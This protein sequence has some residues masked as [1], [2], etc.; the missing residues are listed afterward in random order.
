MK[1][2]EDGEEW[3]ENEEDRI[4]CRTVHL[5]GVVNCIPYIHYIY[6]SSYSN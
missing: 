3:E 5:K 1:S 4:G 6:H 2:D